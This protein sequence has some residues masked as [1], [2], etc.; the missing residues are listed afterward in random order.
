MG[1]QVIYVPFLQAG[2]T[3]I[4]Q[5][6]VFVYSS[7]PALGNLIASIASVAG[8]DNFGNVYQAGMTEYLTLSGT[9]YAVGLNTLSGTGLPGLSLQDIA[10]LPTSP[11]GF[12]GESSG[13]GLTPQAFAAITSGQANGP[14]VASFISVLSQVQSAV[15]GGQIVVQAGDVQFDV[16]GNLQDFVVNNSGYPAYTIHSP[17]PPG[18]FNYGHFENSAAANQLINSLIATSLTGSGFAV[19]STS[20]H[21]IWEIFYTGNQAAG[22]PSFAINLTGG[23]TV[24]FAIGEFKF[25][26]SGGLTTR[27]NPTTGTF[28]NNQLGPTLVVAETHA[29]IEAWVTFTNAGVIN[30]NAAESLAG[31]TFNINVCMSRIEKRQ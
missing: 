16:N 8:V 19:D 17:N 12:F 22:Q 20:Y 14:D 4:D 1:W 3:I 5:S 28:T 26:A 15:P 11:A 13:S 21:I 24:G 18:A 25:W 30:I 23:A 6:G 31:D 2:G 27:L 10:N 29:T 9:T 7:T